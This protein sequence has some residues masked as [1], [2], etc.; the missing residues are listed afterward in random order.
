MIEQKQRVTFDEFMEFVNRPENEDR[1]F[2]L[3]NG[4]IV[5]KMGGGASI[6][7]VT[8]NLGGEVRSFCRQHKFPHFLSG[9]AGSYQI[10]GQTF[11]PDFAY[12]ATPFTSAYP[13]P[14]PPL[15]AV[16]VIS[17]T[18]KPRDIRNK[19]EVYL[20]A[21]LLY[22][23]V[24]PE[25]QAVDV[26]RP[27]QLMQTYHLDDVIDLSDLIPGFTLAVRDLFE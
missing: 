16:E 3:I 18:D 14:E 23:E 6:S 2:E 21:G 26:Y 17:P 22:W 1:W 25:D 5:E 19:R 11:M 4:E 12:Q 8:I 9:E 27:G 10:Q 20:R 15:W 13:E 24:Y 7:A